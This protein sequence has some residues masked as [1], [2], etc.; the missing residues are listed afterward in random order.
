MVSEEYSTD[1]SNAEVRNTYSPPY[2]D[3]FKDKEIGTVSEVIQDDGSFKIVK[4]LKRVK[5]PLA[6]LRS[7]ITRRVREQNAESAE[8]NLIQK[9]R[10]ESK[11][12][13]IRN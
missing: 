12:E 9:L 3:I 13:I 10:A 2:Q 4:L 1:S 8:R 6:E 7:H 11:I 5:I